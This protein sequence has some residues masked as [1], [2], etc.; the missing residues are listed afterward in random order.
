VLLPVILAIIL[1]VALVGYR[2]RR[3]V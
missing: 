2:I 3:S 1:V